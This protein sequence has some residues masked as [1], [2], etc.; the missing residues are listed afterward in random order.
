M[1]L[2][3]QAEGGDV[4]ET[5]RKTNIVFGYE[6]STEFHKPSNY[7]PPPTEV[8][9]QRHANRGQMSVAQIKATN[10]R[11]SVPLSGQW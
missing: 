10:S 3:L 7:M 9:Q 1:D 8:E 11:S 2:N 6:N 5:I 4:R